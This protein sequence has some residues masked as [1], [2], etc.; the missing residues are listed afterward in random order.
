MELESAQN[1]PKNA[2]EVLLSLSECINTAKNLF[3]SYT[4]TPIRIVT[5]NQ[6]VEIIVKRLQRVIRQMGE[7]LNSIKVSSDE[8]FHYAV[9]SLVKDINGFWVE[10]SKVEYVHKENDLYSVT[11]F[12]SSTDDEYESETTHVTKFQDLAN[13][14]MEP[15]YEAFF[16]P[17]TNKIMEDPVTI[18]TG[19]TYERVAITE[20]FEK[21]SNP[22]DIICPKTGINI[23]NRDFNRNNALIEMIKQWEERNEQESIKAA[24]SVLSL[25]SS[26]KPMILEALRNLQNLCRKNLYNVVEIRAIGIIPLLGTIL[27]N[28]DKDLT[29]E[30]LELLRQM[31]ENDDEDEGK[32]MIARTLDLSKLIQNLSSKDER[33]RQ[34]TLMLL[35]ELSKDRFFCDQ[36]SSVSGGMLMLIS[37]KYRQHVDAFFA[38]KIDE[39]LKNLEISPGN[40]KIMAENGHW[41]PLL[42]QF[43]KGNEETKMEMAGYIGELF[44]GHDDEIKRR[45]AETAS[46]AL[47]QMA[48]HGNSLARNVAFRA[49]K[50]ISSHPENGN[51]LV[52]SGTVTNMLQEIFKR[53][54]YDEP[55]NSKAEAAGILAN[56]LESG[57]GELNDL[58]V[59]RKMSLDYIIYNLVRRIGNSMPDELNVNFVRILSCLMK[60]AKS[61]DIIVSVVKESDV[62]TNL[63]ELLNNPNE[64]IQVTSI[65]FC[66]ALSPFIGHTLA[67]RL[68][69]I[70]GQPQALLKDLNET[71]PPTEKQAVSVNFLAKLPHENISLNLALFTSVPLVLRKIDQVMKSGMR[72]SKFGSSYLEGLVGILVRFTY[73][74]YEN[75]FLI[76]AKNFNFA[77]VFTDLLMNTF[78]DEIQ[79]LSANGLANLS[80]KTV[81]LSKPAQIKKK[82]LRR[83]AYI[84]KCSSFYSTNIEDIPLCPVHKGACSSQET[85]CLVEAKAVEKLLT[86][87][88]HRNI[89]VVDAALSAIS[90]LLDERVNLD[91]SVSILIEEK[92][93]QHVL[94]VV[95]EH[96]SENVRQK[97][98][99]ILE[100]LLIEGDD[101]SVSEVS[102]DRLLRSTLINVL[103]RGDGDVRLMAEKILKQLNTIN[104]A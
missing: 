37:V 56:I 4:T 49:L 95:K 21:F 97:S 3:L 65:V 87:F 76:L 25:N 6:E 96:K 29:F 43:I 33:I 26:T 94:N 70:K 24:R 61:R 17:L 19:V 82:K 52:K 85:F 45:V 23:K 72:M 68:C 9:Q 46:P 35:V 8:Y 40:I 100:K 18:E 59:D 102:Q 67:D 74:L 75:Q 69:K 84:L 60:F 92:G 98:L 41:Q 47:I 91:K 54:I 28:E 27:K 34:A 1:T 31:T 7:V 13:S 50:Q 66:I 10:N 2:A 99:W 16:C 44:I 30:T 58:Q 62:C 42:H 38:K 83:F 57:C 89:K 90:T 36:I 78:S 39:I 22:T 12:E 86:C 14:Y 71:M 64:E 93:I 101:K 32:E 73:T 5:P 88:D 20:W 103:H 81:T 15:L 55:M 53:S 63:I 104:Y 77:T 79:I 11:D 48:F 80:V 51:F